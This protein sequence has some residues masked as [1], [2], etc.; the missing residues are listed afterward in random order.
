MVA[1]VVVVARTGTGNVKGA[2][3]L[4]GWAAS[5]LSAVV[6]ELMYVAPKVL[7]WARVATTAAIAIIVIVSRWGHS[8]IHHNSWVVGQDLQDLLLVGTSRTWCLGPHLWV[9]P[10]AQDLL[11][12]RSLLGLG[13]SCCAVPYWGCLRDLAEVG[14]L[15]WT[16]GSRDHHSYYDDCYTSATARRVWLMIV[17]ATTTTTTTNSN[18]RYYNHSY[19][20]CNYDYCSHLII[21]AKVV[22]TQLLTI[23]SHFSTMAT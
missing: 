2:I 15:T 16:L 12:G 21:S 23:L 13:Y 1:V 3:L 20:N 11:V 19:N 18:H 6:V 14:A 7:L 10:C 17:A 8:H 5:K 4:F 22:L 9:G